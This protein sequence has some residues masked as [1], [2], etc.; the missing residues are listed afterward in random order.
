M[1]SVLTSSII[2]T[3]NMK[4]YSFLLT[5]LERFPYSFSIGEATLIIEGFLFKV[6]FKLYN[7]HYKS[8]FHYRFNFICCL[9]SYQQ[10]IQ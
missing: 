5:L 8:V 10:L 9:Y 4:S 1:S 3:I 6:F 2:T 7:D